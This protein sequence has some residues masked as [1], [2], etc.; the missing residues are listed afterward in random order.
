MKRREFLKAGAVAVMGGGLIKMAPARRE[1]IGFIMPT[2]TITVKAKKGCKEVKAHFDCEKVMFSCAIKPGCK[3]PAIGNT[4]YI[5]WDDE[6]KR[7]EY[8]VTKV[9]NTEG[10]HLHVC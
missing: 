6:P 3:M 2:Y 9:E 5:D 7:K 1:Q 8:V 4:L 10:K